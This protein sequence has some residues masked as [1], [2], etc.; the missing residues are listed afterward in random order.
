MSVVERP[1][2]WNPE[3]RTLREE[4]G[5]GKSPVLLASKKL[6]VLASLLPSLTSQLGPPS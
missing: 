4:A 1:L 6:A 2:V 3:I 5:E